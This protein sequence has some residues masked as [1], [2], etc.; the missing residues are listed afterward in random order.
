MRPLQRSDAEALLAYR[1]LPEVARFQSWETFTV[2][3]A[4]VLIE[5]MGPWRQL[6]IVI[7]S[8]GTLAGDCG[9]HCVNNDPRQIEIGITLSPRAQG[10]GYATEAVQCL[11]DHLFTNSPAHRI[12]ATADVLNSPAVALFRRL[13]FREEAHFQ[14]H[15]WF[16]GRWG[17]E[18]LFAILKREWRR[19]QG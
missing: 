9:V 16:K 17:S 18:F 1:S 13:G 8:D 19:R 15:I 2:E 5:S 14:E 6:G 4:L 3:D 7:Q 12:F 10:K 11:V